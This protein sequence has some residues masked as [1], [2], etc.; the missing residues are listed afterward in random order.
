MDIAILWSNVSMVL[1]LLTAHGL[2]HTV[3]YK[4]MSWRHAA[5]S[6]AASGGSLNG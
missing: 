3:F 1:V 6:A 5:G 4:R 2:S